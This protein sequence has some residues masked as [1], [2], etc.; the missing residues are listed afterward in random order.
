MV[1]FL[2]QLCILA[3]FI[4]RNIRRQFDSTDISVMFGCK[5]LIQPFFSIKKYELHKFSL[6]LYNGGLR[7]IYFP[8]TVL[9]V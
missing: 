9:S 5:I 4:N 8:V 6:S 1:N 7:G 2:S 3:L